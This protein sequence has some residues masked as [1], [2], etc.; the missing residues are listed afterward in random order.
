MT[1][2]WQQYH[3]RHH[4]AAPELRVPRYGLFFV[5]F[6]SRKKQLILLRQLPRATLAL[7]IPVAPQP[8]FR[9]GVGSLGFQGLG[10]RAGV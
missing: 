1:F 10:F 6:P 5:Q 7:R 9:W 4:T 2:G 8:E 3:F